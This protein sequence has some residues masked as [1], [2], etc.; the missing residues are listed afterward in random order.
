MININIK[1]D[2]E[3]LRFAGDSIF[4]PK[5]YGGREVELLS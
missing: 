1:E 3:C 5:I 2:Q 4:S